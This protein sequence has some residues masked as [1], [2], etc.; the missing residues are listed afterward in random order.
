MPQWRTCPDW[1]CTPYTCGC[2]KAAV[3]RGLHV[4]SCRRYTSRH[5]R[6]SML[7]DIVLSVIKCAKIPIHKDPTGLRL[8]NS[9]WPNGTTLILWSIGESL[10]CDV[11]VPET[12]AVCHLQ[13]MALEAGSAANHAAEMKYTKYQELDAIQAYSSPMA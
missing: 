4:L 5:Q 11:T 2:G 12:Y 7:N 8:L 1:A 6:H 10:A 13:S 9:K 3:T